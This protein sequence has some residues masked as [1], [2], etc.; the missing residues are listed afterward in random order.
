MTAAREDDIVMTHTLV[1]PQVDARVRWSSRPGAA[2]GHDCI[3]CM[4]A[5]YMQ[6]I[7]ELL[8]DLEARQYVGPRG[9]WFRP[10]LPA[11]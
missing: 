8:D 1:N 5:T 9:P 10:R 7:G 4:I 6:R 2:R 3:R 11:G